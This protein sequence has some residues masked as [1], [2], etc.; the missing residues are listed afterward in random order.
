M[1]KTL[2]SSLC[3]YKNLGP[4]KEV[5]SHPKETGTLIRNTAPQNFKEHEQHI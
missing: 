2:D 5:V 1:G 4:L 3:P